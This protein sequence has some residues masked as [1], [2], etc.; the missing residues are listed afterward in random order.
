MYGPWTLLRIKDGLGDGKGIRVG[1]G[2]GYGILIVIP[3]PVWVL[4]MWVCVGGGVCH[5]GRGF[6]RNIHAILFLGALFFTEYNM[7]NVFW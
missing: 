4:C 5:N 2:E 6:K 1:S 7:E 3:L